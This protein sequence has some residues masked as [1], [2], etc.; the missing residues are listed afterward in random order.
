V[1]YGNRSVTRRRYDA[2]AEVAQP[3]VVDVCAR[4]PERWAW[5][6][7][8]VSA[9]AGA[10]IA[11]LICYWEGIE[12][13]RALVIIALSGIGTGIAV[14]FLVSL[15]LV[16]DEVR[17]HREARP[18]PPQA[19]QVNRPEPPPQTVPIIIK[20]G[21]GKQAHE[22]Y[23]DLPIPKQGPE[24]LARYFWRVLREDRALAFRNP[25]KIGRDDVQAVKDFFTNPEN[26]LGE[27]LGGNLGVKPNDEGEDMMRQFVRRHYPD[28]HLP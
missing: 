5:W 26:G 14:P 1:G 11:T 22:R 25:Y 18:K 13:Q 4:L 2:E 9:P 3:S 21:D 15:F 7:G 8:R 19:E 12:W 23:G 16:S 10:F 28:A 6:L 27:D 24:A 17:A 20:R